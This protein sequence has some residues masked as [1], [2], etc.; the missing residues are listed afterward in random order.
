MLYASGVPDVVDSALFQEMMSGAGVKW[1]V[2]S[3]TGVVE[4]DFF[5]RTKYVKV[6]D[7]QCG[8]VTAL[9]NLNGGAV[10]RCTLQ[11][12]AKVVPA[13]TAGAVPLTDGS[14][15]FG[16]IILQN[17]KPGPRGNLGLNVLR[18]LTLARSDTYLGTSFQ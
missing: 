5:D 3:A 9:Q 4:G 1:G 18:G 2:K 15:N 12:V 8:N 10:A 14:G 11:A 6:S 17:P 16:K 13:G 7:P